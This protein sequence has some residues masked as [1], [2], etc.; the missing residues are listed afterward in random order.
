MQCPASSIVPKEKPLL[1]QVMMVHS[2]SSIELGRDNLFA[3]F[4][5]NSLVNKKQ[6]FG[7]W[8]LGYSVSSMV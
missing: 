6:G 5:F 2:G 3:F 8:G 7:V 1:L 4:G